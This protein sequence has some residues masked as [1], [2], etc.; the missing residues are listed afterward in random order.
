MTDTTDDTKTAPKPKVMRSRQAVDGPES[1]PKPQT[2]QGDTEVVTH[3]LLRA[4]IAYRRSQLYVP[5]LGG[6][7]GGAR[8]MNDRAV[9]QILLVLEDLLTWMSEGQPG[10]AASLTQE[11]LVFW[12][13]A[14]RRGME[15]PD[16]VKRALPPEG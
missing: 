10:A 8:A 7:I 6:Q 5:R 16:D 4:F 9:Q 15:I 11:D 13:D 14:R 3:E 1:P 12:L 2:D